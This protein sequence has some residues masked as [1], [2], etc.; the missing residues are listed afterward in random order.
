MVMP[1]RLTID[2]TRE[3]FSRFSR[4][5]TEDLDD[6][7][8]VDTDRMREAQERVGLPDADAADDAGR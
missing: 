5:R 1:D 7:E 8:R 6:A 4:P 3:A 2:R